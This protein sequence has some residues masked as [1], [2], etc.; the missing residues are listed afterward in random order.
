MKRTFL[1]LL[2]LA[3]I[4]LTSCSGGSSNDPKVVTRK[5]FEAMKTMN[6][7]EA[8]KYAT[9]E[10]KSMLDMMKMGMA[11]AAANQDSIKAEMA[12]QKIEFSEPVINGDEATVAVTVDGKDK[13][14][15]KLKKEEGEW[16]VAF[17]KNTLMKTG[18]EKAQKEGADPADLQEAQRAMEMLKNSDSLKSVLEKAGGS[19]EEAGK[20]LDSMK[21]KQ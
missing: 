3:L 10:S 6:M 20:A 13:T 5:F 19:L 15:F 9:K 12:K 11:F 21:N 14:D 17:D 2:T 16:K 7:E 1:S 18:I 4:F 8:A